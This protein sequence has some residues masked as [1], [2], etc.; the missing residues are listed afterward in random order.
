MSHDMGT[1][2]TVITSDVSGCSPGSWRLDPGDWQRHRRQRQDP[3]CLQR[4]VRAE[5]D[6]R[7]DL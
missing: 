7:E 1:W 6:Q 2:G 5:A 4:G 3:V